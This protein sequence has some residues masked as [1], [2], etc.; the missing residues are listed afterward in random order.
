MNFFNH[1]DN[2]QESQDPNNFNFL[3]S[4]QD[5]F[6]FNQD[7]FGPGEYSIGGEGQSFALSN[8]K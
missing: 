3:D 7:T 8:L 4:N 5:T 2:S 1:N 6:A